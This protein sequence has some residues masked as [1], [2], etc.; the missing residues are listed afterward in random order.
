MD[1]CYISMKKFRIIVDFV[2]VIKDLVW[3]HFH[4]ASHVPYCVFC[5][6][7]DKMY[8]FF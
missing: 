8:Y 6:N 7:P 2:Q 4:I 5:Y 1:H 3:S